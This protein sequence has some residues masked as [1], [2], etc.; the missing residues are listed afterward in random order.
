MSHPCGFFITFEG[1]EG[2]GKSTLSKK[3]YQYLVKQKKA[4]LFTKEP[5]GT[6][7]GKKVRILLLQKKETW[8]S[9]RAELLLFLADRAQHVDELIIPAL[10]Q[11]QIVLC[12]RF[13]DSTRAYQGAGRGF[14]TKWLES[15]LQFATNGLQPDLTFYL[16]VDP[17]IGFQRAKRE[18]RQLDRM[19]Q[20]A[21]AFHKKVR[22]AFASPWG[23]S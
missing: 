20:E 16:D 14:S 17:Q 15:L 8:I 5:G 11:G 21:L 7:L 3:I 18:R 1:G 23:G 10:Q 4:V 6:K 22:K 9:P 2:A 19:E 13:S 12:D